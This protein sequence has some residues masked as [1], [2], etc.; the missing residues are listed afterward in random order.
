MAMAAFLLFSSSPRLSP[1]SFAMGT[2]T[3]P[4]WG[5]GEWIYI[6][7]RTTNHWGGNVPEVTNEASLMS[8]YKNTG[9]RCIIV[10]A[11]EGPSEFNG[12]YTFPQ[13]NTNEAAKAHD[14]RSLIFGCTRPIDWRRKRHKDSTAPPI[15]KRFPDCGTGIRKLRC[16]RGLA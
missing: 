15:L 9:V 2:L 8:F 3:R 5:R 7:Q 11:G 1:A 10:K 4:I 16:S 14:V 13:I 6:M 12:N